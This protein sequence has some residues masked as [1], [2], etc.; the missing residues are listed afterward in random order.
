M[1]LQ[2]YRYYQNL[3]L[4]ENPPI[5]G[6]L[7]AAMARATD[8]DLSQLLK[9]FP[10]VWEEFAHRYHGPKG[11]LSVEEFVGICREEHGIE[12]SAEKR[13]RTT[14]LIK[15][16]KARAAESISKG[17]E[18]SDI[19][20]EKMVSV[21]SSELPQGFERQPENLEKLHDEIGGLLR[22]LRQ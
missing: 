8:S 6:L 1:S 17:L 3:C 16:A 12:L 2:D 15:E 19:L 4:H 18:Q 22:E 11:A 13:A 21:A 9:A 20:P 14:K 5:R 7:M 10:E